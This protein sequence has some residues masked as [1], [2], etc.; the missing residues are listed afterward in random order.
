METLFGRFPHLVEDIFGLLN[1]KTLSCCFQIDK[2][3]NAN[4][5]GYR[6]FVVRKT[7]KHL[8]NQNIEFGPLTGY[9]KEY[10][11][12]LPEIPLEQLSLP[13]FLQFLRYLCDSKLKDCKINLRNMSM[14]EDTQW[15]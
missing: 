14:E 15:H 4:L 5:E 12:N 9:D 11:K 2:I 3:W 7:K 1:G 8:Q 10:R 6:L 13:F